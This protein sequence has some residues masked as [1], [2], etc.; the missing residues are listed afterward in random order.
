[1]LAAAAD[2]TMS[3][4]P[5]ARRSRGTDAPKDDSQLRP[6]I[7][8]GLAL[9]GGV[10]IAAVIALLILGN[11]GGAGQGNLAPGSGPGDTRLFPPAG[12]VAAQTGSGSAGHGAA[13]VT[14]SAPQS[15]PAGPTSDAAASQYDAQGTRGTVLGDP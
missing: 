2:P 3:R 14:R 11:G 1:M 7:W 8:P 12:Q 6:H 4:A 9:A 15:G 5:P 10:V 13:P